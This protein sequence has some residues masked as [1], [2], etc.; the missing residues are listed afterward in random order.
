MGISASQ[1][2]LLF[3]TARLSDNE[4]QQQ[5]IAF[6][7]ER[8]ADRAE[9]VNDRY[10]EALNSTKYQI[11][12]GYNGVNANY[13]DLT[14]NHLT[15]YNCA[16]NGRQY[17]VKNNKGKVLV[18]NELAKAFKQY[19]G[20]FNR[21][22]EAMGYT[23]SNIN[24][25][26]AT[27]SEEAMHDAWDRYLVSI[28][29]SINN[30]GE[31]H[32]HILDFGFSSYADGIFNGY[33]VFRSAAATSIVN[34]KTTTESLYKDDQ[35]YYLNRATI[36]AREDDQG[37]FYACY[38]TDAQLGTDKYNVLA[39]VSYNN[40]TG[41]FTYGEKEY[42]V[43]YVNPKNSAISDTKKEYLRILSDSSY[44]SN[45]GIR[46]EVVPSSKA[47]NFEGTTRDQRELYDYAVALTEAYSKGEDSSLKYDAAMVNYYRNIFNEM[48]SCGYT[49]ID[50]EVHDDNNNVQES[51]F[52]DNQWFVN[53][54]KSGA[55]TISYYSTTSRMFVGTTMDDDSAITEK[56][57]KSKIA[58]AEQEYNAQMDKIER[59]EKQF[60][61]QLNKLEA[62]HNALNT[63][64]ESLQKVISNNISKSFKT[65]NS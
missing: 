15:G 53:Q 32:E 36:V 17:L 22:L 52:K 25:K 57:D 7:K 26:N 62:E 30:K 56:E 31:L 41:K 58:I 49:T 4:F 24:V 35:G 34:G 23:Q 54:L 64:L 59:D 11:L 20:D 14:Y 6:T 9:G 63:E 2:K 8:L 38:Q 37:N 40:D 16:L 18:P 47:I 33:P 19:N 42:S 21:F 29:E 65:F 55:L 61:M 51:N 1:G 39:N 48:M 12:S 45:D 13:E 60:D 50:G 3:M 28:G 10:L 44:I 46:Y 5:S 27:E 43:L